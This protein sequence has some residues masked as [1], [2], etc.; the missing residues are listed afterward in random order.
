MRE[1]ATEHLE[2]SQP[3]CDMG[4]WNSETPNSGLFGGNR[5]GRG[6]RGS[7]RWGTSA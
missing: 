5:G 1:E 4:R 2:E 6:G 7:M 3:N